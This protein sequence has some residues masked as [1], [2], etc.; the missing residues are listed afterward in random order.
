MA[1]KPFQRREKQIP[2]RKWHPC[3][4][5]MEKDGEK[6]AALGVPQQIQRLMQENHVVARCLDI[7]DSGTRDQKPGSV[8][9]LSQARQIGLRAFLGGNQREDG[10]KVIRFIDFVNGRQVFLGQVLT[11][12]NHFVAPGTQQKCR[13]QQA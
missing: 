2:N 7:R 1:K 12:V 3:Q 8:K 13:K 4:L 5:G 9:G 10:K 6:S 11:Q